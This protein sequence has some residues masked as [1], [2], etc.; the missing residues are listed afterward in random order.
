VEKLK[1]EYDCEFHVVSGLSG[2]NVEKVFDRMS[3]LVFEH[4]LE[5]KLGGN[6]MIGSKLTNPV[7]H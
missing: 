7:S 6:K 1:Q 3:Q 4:Y 5:K 2:E